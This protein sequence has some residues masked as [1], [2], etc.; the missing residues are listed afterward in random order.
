MRRFSLAL[1]WPM[2]SARRAGRSERSYCRS[3]SVTLVLKASVALVALGMGE[4]N[5]G[6]ETGNRSTVR[7]TIIQLGPSTFQGPKHSS[8]RMDEQRM[9]QPNDGRHR[10]PPEI[11]RYR[12]LERASIVPPPDRDEQNFPRI[13]YRFQELSL[14][15]QRKLVK[16]GLLYIY[17]A[18]VNVGILPRVISEGR[19]IG[20]QQTKSFSPIYLHKEIIVAVEVEQRNCGC[21]AQ[22]KSRI[23]FQ[24]I[25]QSI[26]VILWQAHVW[27][28]VFDIC[29]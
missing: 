5:R 16:I 27:L 2:Y 17:R 12:F 23:F 21:R 4:L 7:W 6:C 13:H 25:L 20:R 26:W 8:F 22:E 19:L 14:C 11:Q 10:I 28:K 3:S 9:P 24:E 29:F 18:V 1:V 15:E